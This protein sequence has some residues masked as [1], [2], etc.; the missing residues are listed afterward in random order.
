MTLVLNA[1]STYFETALGEAMLE[2]DSDTWRK[3]VVLGLSAG[4]KFLVEALMMFL[5]K[6]HS[7]PEWRR[8]Q[9][10]MNRIIAWLKGVW[11]WMRGKDLPGG[12]ATE[13]AADDG[14][15]PPPDN[16]PLSVA[17]NDPKLKPLGD[18]IAKLADKLRLKEIP[19]D[20][21]L[22]DKT[23]AE[24]RLGDTVARFCALSNDDIDLPP[25]PTLTLPGATIGGQK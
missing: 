2:D 15:R 10:S 20:N 8:Y 25:V 18:W 16:D 17:I 4:L 3:L 22:G 14:D 1:A 23:I 11:D 5:I 6:F 24:E 12:G 21:D 7:H 13:G 9:N 19:T